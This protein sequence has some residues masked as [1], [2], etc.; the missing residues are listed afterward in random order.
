MDTLEGST[1]IKVKKVKQFDFFFL[2]TC[3][4]TMNEFYK[5]EFQN[6]FSRF[7]KQSLSKISGR[8]M[9]TIVSGFINTMF[10]TSFLQSFDG[11]RRQS[12]IR[13]MTAFVFAHRHNKDDLFLKES[14]ID[15]TVLRDCMYR[16][17][18]KAQ[19]HFFSQGI[20][21]FFFAHFASS[22]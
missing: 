11:E 19:D 20:E 5:M 7:A 13:S 15:F 2:R 6:Y 10:G 16:Y 8:E 3:F 22:P 21:T 9:E 18:K 4:R 17:S 1:I 14:G 12:I